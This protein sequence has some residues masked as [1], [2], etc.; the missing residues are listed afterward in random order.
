VVL[1]DFVQL[2][3]DRAAVVTADPYHPRQLRVTVSGARPDGPAPQVIPY[4]TT[5]VRV[6]TQVEVEVQQFDDT[7]GSDLAWRPV[8]AAVAR[9]V[10]RNLEEEARRGNPPDPSVLWAGTVNFA[11]PP[12]AGRFRLMIREYEYISAEYTTNPDGTTNPA[13][14][15]DFTPETRIVGAAPRRLVYAEAIAIDAA[16]VSEPSPETRETKID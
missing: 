2:T 13:I 10:P 1:A 15:S 8:D 5:P 7:I 16:L 9:A 14:P 4:P 3:S 11:E 6:P 12:T